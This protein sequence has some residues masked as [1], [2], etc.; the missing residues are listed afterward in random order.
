M[1]TNAPPV[2]APL[3]GYIFI[4]GA[5]DMPEAYRALWQGKW[6]YFAK[7]TS[8]H[9]SGHFPITAETYAAI[10]KTYAEY[11]LHHNA[12]LRSKDYRDSV[13][14]NIAHATKHNYDEGLE[15]LFEIALSY[16]KEMLWA[17][18]RRNRAEAAF[19]ELAREPETADE[20]NA[21]E[22]AF[23]DAIERMKAAP[24]RRVARPK[25]A[26]TVMH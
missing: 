20:I 14:E 2:T 10:A 26:R 12:Y 1:S 9:I 23:A 21:R 8:T 16:E 7:I 5:G 17:A 6:G 25:K 18:A 11:S 3:R 15:T 24:L 13:D 4:A 22:Q 19:L